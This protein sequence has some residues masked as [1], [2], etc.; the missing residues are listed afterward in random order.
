MAK[1]LILFRHAKSSWDDPVGDHER[2]LTARGIHAARTMG[3]FLA[4]AGR[5]P[6]RAI[7]SSARRARRTYDL[8]AEAGDW[9][10]ECRVSPSLYLSEPETVLEEIQGEDRA[11][12]SLL[13]VGHEPTW[14]E[15]AG[16][17][18]GGATRLRFPTAAMAWIELDAVD[19][20]D[21]SFSNAMLRALIP[22]KLLTGAGFSFG[23]D[24]E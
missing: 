10:C 9:S 3:R 20:G 1:T 14:S 11:A 19:W 5:V 22:P 15:I 2:D 13:L 6:D 7:V 18:A 24:A 16:L 17:A 23:V 21:A 12:A 8:A 4:A